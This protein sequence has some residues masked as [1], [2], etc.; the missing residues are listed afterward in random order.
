MSPARTP[1]IRQPRYS[2]PPVVAAP[3]ERR[4]AWVNRSLTS[5]GREYVHGMRIVFSA[6][7]AGIFAGLAFMFAVIIAGR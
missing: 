4:D 5:G 7:L 1:L 3:I 6:W 2:N